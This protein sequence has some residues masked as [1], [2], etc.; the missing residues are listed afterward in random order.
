MSAARFVIIA[1]AAAAAF[2]TS[3]SRATLAQAA[4]K[5]VW[6]GVYTTAQAQRGGEVYKKSCGHCHR[7]DLEGGGS[8]VGAPALK[9]PIF[10]YRWNDQPLSEMFLTIG[11]TMPQ[12]AP[13]TLTPQTV[14]DVVAF[15]LHSNDLPAG[16]NELPPSVDALKDILMID[17][18]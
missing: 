3:V 11:A 7:D 16:A 8:E 1:A 15:L 12:N 2:A 9:G 4:S 6:D 5:T 17:K 14:A 10:I 13:D 18:R